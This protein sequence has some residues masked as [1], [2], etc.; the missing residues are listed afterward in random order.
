MRQLCSRLT[1]GCKE[2]CRTLP[3]AAPG[4]TFFRANEISGPKLFNQ[5][6]YRTRETRLTP[7][8]ASSPPDFT[9]STVRLVS[10]Q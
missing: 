4:S 3:E 1:N 7:N 10:L 2:C 5:R 8:P 6:K 9:G